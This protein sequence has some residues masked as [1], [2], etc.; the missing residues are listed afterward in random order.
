MEAARKAAVEF[1]TTQDSRTWAAEVL[2]EISKNTFLK[3]REQGLV[4]EENIKRSVMAVWAWITERESSYREFIESKLYWRF[5][6]LVRDDYSADELLRG[7]EAPMNEASFKLGIPAYQDFYE[8]SVA[9]VAAE[10]NR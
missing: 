3:G 5:R 4:D 6:T 2:V 10:L 7:L 8:R 1:A 9:R